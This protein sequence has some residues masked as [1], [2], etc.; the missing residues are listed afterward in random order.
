MVSGWLLVVGWLWF[1][2]NFALWRIFGQLV[3]RTDNLKE[4]NQRATNNK[5]QAQRTTPHTEAT[6]TCNISSGVKL[7]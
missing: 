1:V 2:G 4:D 3:P 5:L 6:A 7:G